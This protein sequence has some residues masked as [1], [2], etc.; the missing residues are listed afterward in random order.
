MRRKT[1]SHLSLMRYDASVT[2]TMTTEKIFVASLSFLLVVGG[3]AQPSSVVRTYN[4]PTDCTFE[5]GT[6]GWHDDNGGDDFKWTLGSGSTTNDIRYMA[7]LNDR[8]RNNSFGGYMFVK[9]YAWSATALKA[10]LYSNTFKSNYSEC[11]LKF[12]Y[13]LTGNSPGHLNIYAKY[14]IE[15]DSPVTKLWSSKYL[16]YKESWQEVTVGVGGGREKLFSLAF[17]LTDIP[18]GFDGTAAV[19]DVTF[20]DCVLQEPPLYPNPGS[21]QD[22]L[23]QNGLCISGSKLC[24]V[25]HDCGDGSDEDM[26]ICNTYHKYDFESHTDFV[27]GNDTIEDDFDWSLQSGPTTSLL[28]GPSRDHTKGTAGGHYMY[29]EASRRR[30]RERAWL[31]MRPFS[32]NSTNCRLRFFYH[33]YGQHAE[34]LSV[35]IRTH[36]NSEPEEIWSKGEPEVD[37]WLP[38]GDIDLTLPSTDFQVIFE[39][40]VGVSWLGDI[41][42]DD[43]SFTPGCK[44][45]NDPTLPLADIVTTTAPPVTTKQPSNCSDSQFECVTTRECIGKQQMCDFR[46]DCKDASDEN[47]CPKQYCTFEDDNLDMADQLCGWKIEVDQTSDVVSPSA[48]YRWEVAQGSGEN[49]PDNDHTS[50]SSKGYYVLADAKPGTY[51]DTSNFTATISRTGPQCRLG[52]WYRMSGFNGGG[53]IAIMCQTPTE[54]HEVSVIT[55]NESPSWN[56]E[57]VPIGSQENIRVIIQTRRGLSW[58]TGIAIDDVYFIDCQPPAMSRQCLEDE[59]TCSNGYCISRE[60]KCDYAN[61]CGDSSDENEKQCNTFYKARCDFEHGMCDSWTHDETGDYFWRLNKHGTASLQTGPEYDQ[62]EHSKEG[63]YIY[64]E[65]SGPQVVQGETVRLASRVIKGGLKDCKLRYWYHM[66]GAQIGSLNIVRRYSFFDNGTV[67]L[68]THR[69][70]Q[71]R[72]W[73]RGEVDL[74][75]PENITKQNF[76]V[77]LEGV[78]GSGFVGDIA[79]DSLS[80]TPGCE[81][82]NENVLPGQPDGPKPLQNN[83]TDLGLHQCNSGECYRARQRCDFI[84]DCDD[85]T[86]EMG[87]GSRCNFQSSTCGWK[88]Q[89]TGATTAHWMRNKHELN[90][91]QTGSYLRVLFSSQTTTKAILES[92]L[93]TTASHS[94]SFKFRYQLSEPHHAGAL[95]IKVKDTYGHVT[96]VWSAPENATSDWLEASADVGGHVTRDFRVLIEAGEPKTSASVDD[97][98]FKDCAKASTSECGEGFFLCRDNSSCVENRYVCDKTPDCVDQ[99]DEDRGIC[100]L[101]EGDCDFEHKMDWCQWK[102]S[103]EWVRESMESFSGY[104]KRSAKRVN[105]FFAVTDFETERDAKPGDIA[106][107]TT[108]VFPAS[109]PDCYM[110]FSYRMYDPKAGVIGEKDNMG[111]LKVSTLN[112]DNQTSLM[113]IKSGNQGNQWHK[114]NIPVG[115]NQ[116]YSVLFEAVRGDGPRSNIAMDDVSFTPEC[117]QAYL[118]GYNNSERHCD[119]PMFYCGET[120]SCLPKAWLCDGTQDCGAHDEVDCLS[121]TTQVTP[122]FS[123]GHTTSTNA[124]TADPR[125]GFTIGPQTCGKGKF[126]CADGKCIDG[127]LYCDQVP[128]CSAGDDEYGCKHQCPVGA[129]LCH[130]GTECGCLCDSNTQCI[131]GSDEAFCNRD[132]CQAD[133]R[134]CYGNSTCSY[135]QGMGTQCLNCSLANAGRRCYDKSK[136]VTS[137]QPPQTT[138]DTNINCTRPYK[139]CK[140]GTC[141]LASQFCDF[142]PDC[143]DLS[144]EEACPSICAFEGGQTC[145]WHSRNCD[146]CYQWTL[147]SAQTLSSEPKAPKFDHTLGTR[148]GGFMYVISEGIENLNGKEIRL[149]SPV[150]T[151]GGL[152]CK[153]SFWYHVYGS[154]GSLKLSVNS[155]GQVLDLWVKTPKAVDEWQEASVEL[156]VCL[157]EFQ[158]T[159]EARLAFNWKGG[160]AVDDIRMQNCHYKKNPATTGYFK[161]KDGNYIPPDRQCDFQTD[162]CDASDETPVICKRETRQCDFE[163]D[164]C[165][166]E[167]LPGDINWIRKNG[168]TAS[169][170][171]GPRRDHTLL[172]NDGHYIYI[173][174]SKPAT[175]NDKA[176][177]GQYFNETDGI[178]QIRFWYHM[179]GTDV[180]TLNIYVRKLTSSKLY[181]IDTRVGNQ[182]NMWHRMDFQLSADEAFHIILEGVVGNG[183]TGDIALDD[184]SYTKGCSPYYGP[185]PTPET[186]LQSTVAPI[187][188]HPTDCNFEFN[189]C[190]WYEAYT[191]EFDWHWGSGHSTLEEPNTAPR[192]DHTRDTPNGYYMYVRDNTVANLASRDAHLRSQQIQATSS[193]CKVKFFYYLNTTKLTSSTTT[194]LGLTVISQAA[195]EMDKVRLIW[196]QAKNMGEKWNEAV[197]GIGRLAKPFVFEFVCYGDGRGRRVVAIDDVTFFDCMLGEPTS[198]CDKDSM[199]HCPK[200]RVCLQTHFKC[201]MTDNCGKGEDEEKNLCEGYKQQNFENGLGHFNQGRDG[202]DDDFDWTWV[203]GSSPSFD[204]GP[205]SDHTMNS[206]LGHYLHIETSAP[207]KENDKA[208][209]LSRVFVATNGK[210]ESCNMRFYYHM[211]GEE[212]DRLAVYARY[213]RSGPAQQLLWEE[214]GDKGNFWARGEVIL[215]EKQDFQ[216]IF[217]GTVGKGWK[218]DI[219]IDDISFTPG[220]RY[221]DTPLPEYQHVTSE[222]GKRSLD[223]A[224]SVPITFILLVAIA[225]GA[226]FIYRREK[227]KK[228]TLRNSDAYSSRRN[229]TETTS[230]SFVDDEPVSIVNPLYTIVNPLYNSNVANGHAETGQRR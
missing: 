156:P 81:W 157:K 207:R 34:K 163:V 11:K 30:Y 184:F 226:F 73:L 18:N 59:F 126:T 23:C 109:Q 36:R 134:Y 37:T 15:D 22:Y 173:E 47:D 140:D 167:K 103:G 224:I 193:E 146:N 136:P 2:R 33:M 208:W 86:D 39:G 1:K 112:K 40:Q 79:L 176:R 170:G 63:F 230:T 155:S 99:S 43:V 206:K 13:Y 5:T 10:Q 14:G 216:V 144:D 179:Y 90:S 77:I 41:A 202:T 16:P 185:T 114:A 42:I 89:F 223:V 201:D 78:V 210:I 139:Q 85:G 9:D 101:R 188:K 212:V 160:I 17:L 211:F 150:Y 51:T 56:Q 137:P 57:I 97:I 122:G 93:Y 74:T 48:L 124:P 164:W 190:G 71:G 128:D 7:P 100:V 141:I 183:Y 186:E 213:F 221:S 191:D 169:V 35:K 113:W 55:H 145:N 129:T 166:W 189:T 21:C 132:L 205:D 76:Q 82:A 70:D 204:T 148:S 72:Y 45:S 174:T 219:A 38:S 121:T 75:Q 209:L 197:V 125:Q 180:N 120:N 158:L 106:S 102:N 220:C 108:Q 44:F 149:V 104:A 115:N 32:A 4:P 135:T 50:L 171:T 162:C 228:D 192:R 143:P 130:S 194:K 46:E 153:V 168:T 65:A 177:I 142:K 105:S 96:T 3:L 64:L 20:F 83:C 107:L 110:R 227:Q 215:D 111:T 84:S 6:C 195:G 159:I 52:F 53:S 58:D 12:F 151:L 60:K 62:S 117:R 24:D 31:L 92:P 165:N 94:C 196:Q 229:M 54:V 161:C 198:I 217:E 200:T 225:V 182:G 218:G 69:G 119:F 95:Q 29:T 49:R 80:M 147:G 98:Q 61:D 138:E 131:D 26:E 67:T 87:C 8:T 127:A 172:A 28:T 222:T 123:T 66:K 91:N 68:K 88:T 203:N 175:L 25:T 154:F 116:N 214:E 27:Q 19:D 118:P 187:T 181:L 178:C 199:F 133:F 152:T